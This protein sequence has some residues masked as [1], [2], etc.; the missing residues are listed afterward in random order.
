M[1]H[2]KIECCARGY[3]VNEGP[4]L[5][6]CNLEAINQLSTQNGQKGEPGIGTESCCWSLTRHI[7]QSVVRAGGREIDRDGGGRI[8]SGVSS[9]DGPSEWYNARCG[10]Y[11]WKIVCLPVRLCICVCGYT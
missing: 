5:H 3:G 2:A 4:T 1:N 7:R 11:R 9:M 10:G 6:F 8:G